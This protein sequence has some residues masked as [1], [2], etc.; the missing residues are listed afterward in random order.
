MLTLEIG[1]LGK[2]TKNLIVDSTVVWIEVGRKLY[3]WICV[4]KLWGS[5]Y[6]W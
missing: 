2:H 5:W 4:S 1:Y 6:W 3:L